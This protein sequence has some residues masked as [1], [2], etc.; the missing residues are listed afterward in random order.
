MKGRKFWNPECSGQA[1]HGSTNRMSLNDKVCGHE[2]H[3]GHTNR[4][5]V[6]DEILR[7]SVGRDPTY[8]SQGGGF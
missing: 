7:L 1:R 5:L 8:K 4:I 2:A 6:V 3:L